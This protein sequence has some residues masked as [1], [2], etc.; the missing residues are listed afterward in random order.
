MTNE[1]IT[2][3]LLLF[4]QRQ[5]EAEVE[6]RQIL[7]DIAE[8]RKDMKATKQLTEE[9]HIMAVNMTN[10]QKTLQETS[11]KV[12]VLANKELNSYNDT[13]KKIKDSVVGGVTGT[14]LTLIFGGIAILVRLSVKGG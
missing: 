6:R 4:T 11:N 2:E 1:Q 8:L 7:E 5:A 10:M 13:K 12:E 3:K 14:I 9:V